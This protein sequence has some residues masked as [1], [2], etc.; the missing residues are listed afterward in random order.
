MYESLPSAR[1]TE[2]HI[3][4]Y[5]GLSCINRDMAREGKSKR[6]GTDITQIEF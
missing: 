3:N 6:T 1:G 4:S 5:P 2:A